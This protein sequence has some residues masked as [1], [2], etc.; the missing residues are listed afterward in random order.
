MGKV[1]RKGRRRVVRGVEKRGALEW[2]VG[3]CDALVSGGAG[4]RGP[5]EESRGGTD[6]KR[7]W[8][9]DWRGVVSLTRLAGHT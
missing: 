5:I 3:C 6:Q 2:L 4:E 8:S 9:I 1:R 7:A